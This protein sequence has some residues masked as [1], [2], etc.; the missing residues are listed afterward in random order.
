MMTPRVSS[1]CHC[2]PFLASLHDGRTPVLT[3]AGSL[4]KPNLC[5]LENRNVHQPRPA[6]NGLFVGR[7]DD[8]PHVLYRMTSSALHVAP[9]GCLGRTD[10]A[11]NE[12]SGYTRILRSPFCEPHNAIPCSTQFHAG[13]ANQYS[14]GFQF[15]LLGTC[16]R[17]SLRG[18]RLYQIWPLPEARFFD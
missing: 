18:W 2:T 7:T 10:T 11:L 17:S 3:D 6:V 13:E 1:H 12:L 9:A 16:P 5:Q 4:L 15:P 14:L 8:H